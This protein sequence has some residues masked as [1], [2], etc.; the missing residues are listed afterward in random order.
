MIYLFDV[1]YDDYLRLFLS[2]LSLTFDLLHNLIY[3]S[4]SFQHL[5]GLFPVRLDLLSKFLHIGLRTLLQF[6]QRF[7]NKLLPK[8]KLVTHLFKLCNKVPTFSELTKLLA[9]LDLGLPFT[10]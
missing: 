10:S 9:L 1:I 2:F 3:L 8:T 5:S 6:H 7:L 4:H